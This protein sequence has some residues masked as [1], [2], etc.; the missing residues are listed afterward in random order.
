MSEAESRL[1]DL[2]R[3]TDAPSRDLGFVLAVEER[4]ARRAMFIEV[5]GRTATGLVLVAALAGFGPLL[6]A[7]ANVLV[8]SLDAAGPVLAAVAA[9]GAMMVRL[10]R[11]PGDFFSL[12]PEEQG[13]SQT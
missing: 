1:A 6:L 4:I 13:G 12:D 7:R 11:T 9:L 10:T 5:A 2:W 8:G 3:S